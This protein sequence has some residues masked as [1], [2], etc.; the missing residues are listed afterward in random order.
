LRSEQSAPARYPIA[1]EA[2]AREGVD[3]RADAVITP[4]AGDALATP[5]SSRRLD[6]AAWHAAAPARGPH[7]NVDLRPSATRRRPFAIDNARS[8]PVDRDACR[9]T[10]PRRIDWHGAASR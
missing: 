10:A 4:F 5:G 2:V 3:G 9:S 7:V 1:V 6:P 8:G